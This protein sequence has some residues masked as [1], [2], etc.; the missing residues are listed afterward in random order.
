[1]PIARVS[2]PPVALIAFSSTKLERNW[3]CALH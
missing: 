3:S 2:D 1:M